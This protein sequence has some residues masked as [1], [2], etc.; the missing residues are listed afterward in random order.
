MK[1][2][3]LTCST[4]VA[5][6]LVLGV[7]SSQAENCQD[8][9]D[10]NL[11]RCQFNVEGEILSEV[12]LQFVSPGVESAKFDLV[13]GGVNFGCTCKAKGEVDD[14]DFNA[15]KEFFCVNPID[16]T[17]AEALE[18][19]V[20]GSGKKIKGGSYGNS[21]GNSGVIECELDPTCP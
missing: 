9:L 14:P 10:N 17:R 15:S 3:A 2:A 19:R 6:L 13:A 18:G 5:L 11:Y 7:G 1:I 12:C 20:S 8:I 4:A 21:F 16:T